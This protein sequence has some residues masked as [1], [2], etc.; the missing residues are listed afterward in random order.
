MKIIDSHAHLDM[1]A[2]H[3]DRTQVLT[4]AREE[5]ISHIVTVGIDLPSSLSALDLAKEHD[6]VFSTIGYHPHHAKEMGPEEEKA[7][8]ELALEAKVVAWGEIGLDFFHRHSPPEKQ[9]EVF[10]R[11]I[12]LAS[13]AGLPIIIHD[14]DA[15]REVLDILKAG[16]NEKYR[17][18]IHCFS[19][20]HALAA[21][22]IDMGFHLSIPGTVT[23]KGARQVKEVAAK[24]PL[25][26]MLVETDAPFLTPVPF[27]GKRNESS[28]VTHT[29]KE[30]ARLRGISF[31]EVA[32]Q[33]SENAI[34]LFNLPVAP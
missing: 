8:S 19:G 6:F 22:F 4:R 34:R 15:H 12:N 27:R 13:D 10:K 17:G 28:F 9:M 24:I 7:L 23:Y 5:D 30:I 32:K 18:V 21:T 26:R 1:E 20:D 33:T 29:V 2:F 14:R 11:Q 16:S 25:E 3:K 31:E